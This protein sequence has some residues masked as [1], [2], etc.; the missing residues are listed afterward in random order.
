M[1]I[2]LA[3]M[4]ADAQATAM[5]SLIKI[6]KPAIE[7]ALAL[8]KGAKAELVEYAKAEYL[9]ANSGEDGKAPK[10]AQNQATKAY[11]M[12]AAL[13]LGLIGREE[14]AAPMIE[15]IGKSDAIGKVMIARELAKLPASEKNLAAM[16]AVFEKTPIDATIPPGIGARE[17]LLDAMGFLFDANLVP[18]V[19]K[20]ALDTKGEDADLEPARSAALMAAMKLMKAS[21]IAEVDRLANS[22]I[23]GPDGKPSTLGK[24]YEREYRQAKELLK[25]CGDA[26][27]CYYGKLIDPSS[28]ASDKQLIG[29]KSAYM[30]GVLGG[31]EVRAKLVELMPKITGAAAKFMAVQVI[32]RRSP[33]GDVAIAAELEKMVDEAAATKEMNKIAAIA[34][35]KAVIYRLRARAE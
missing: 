23:G 19:V 8:L 29:I 13:I 14:A 4:K 7:P 16:K 1:K 31:P 26:I 9:S 22:R 24:G 35:F 11:V 20:T 18:W 6:G 34:P 25:E 27:D 5:Y 30:V 28:H 10:E 21:Q 2:T 17:A 33:K 15:V 32:D 3:P 12:P